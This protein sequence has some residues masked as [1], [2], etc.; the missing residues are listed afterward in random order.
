MN[1]MY[2]NL[3]TQ[4][5]HVSAKEI[6]D[7]KVIFTFASMNEAQKAAQTFKTQNIEMKVD[8]VGLTVILSFLHK[9]LNASNMMQFKRNISFKATIG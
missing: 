4:G 6:K 7:G 1:S 8:A 2:M 3:K 9:N 5:I